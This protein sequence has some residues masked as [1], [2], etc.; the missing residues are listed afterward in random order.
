MQMKTHPELLN[1]ELQFIPKFTPLG[2][3]VFSSNYSMCRMLLSMGADPDHVCNDQ[4]PLMI[5]SH[6]NNIQIVELL[7]EYKADTRASNSIRL[8]ALDFAILHGNYSIALFFVKE[9]RMI[10][11]KT[12][13]DYFTLGK[14]C[15]VGYY[16]NYKKLI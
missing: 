5:A 9:H 10:V 6:R 2:R 15:A 11:V 7:V 3:A 12:A 4:S 13:D 16:V 8:T 14:K 1:S